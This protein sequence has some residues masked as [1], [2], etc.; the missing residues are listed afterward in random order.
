MGSLNSGG[1]V[2]QE[3]IFSCKAVLSCDGKLLLG[4][5]SDA[6]GLA[7]ETDLCIGMSLSFGCKRVRLHCC[8]HLC[9]CMGMCLCF[10]VLCMSCHLLC[11]LH[12]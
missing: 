3:L 8:L 7:Q 11:L 10:Q 4:R 5:T 6:T 9:F 1:L 12:L 2:H